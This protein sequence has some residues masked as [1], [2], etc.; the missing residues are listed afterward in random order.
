[1]MGKSD[2]SYVWAG[3][4]ASCE[5]DTGTIIG[6]DCGVVMDDDC[7]MPIRGSWWESVTGIAIMMIPGV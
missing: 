4:R 6:D 2:Q 1:M 5:Q 3:C 7:I